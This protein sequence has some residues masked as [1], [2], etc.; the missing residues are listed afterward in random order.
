MTIFLPRLDNTVYSIISTCIQLLV[1]MSSWSFWF[2]K[3]LVRQQ[4]LSENIYPLAH[5]QWCN[6]TL[7]WFPD[8][9][10]GIVTRRPVFQRWLQDVYVL[11]VV[12]EDSGYPAQSST[13]T[14]TIQ[15]CSCE[16]GGS[17]VTCSAEAIFLPVGL[18]TGALMA[19]LLCV[20]L[21]IGK[22]IF[23]LSHNCNIMI[24]WKTK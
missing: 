10:A 12:V 16:A 20:A 18:S 6:I 13:A 5:C 23:L 7:C 15:V 24:W 17:L 21:L 19:I 1:H 14:L 3:S 9:T 2:L 11:P 4:R 22:R 8:N